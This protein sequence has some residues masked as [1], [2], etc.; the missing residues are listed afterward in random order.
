LSQI[1]IFPSHLTHL[2]NVIESPNVGHG[3]GHV[4]PMDGLIHAG[5]SNEFFCPIFQ[6]HKAKWL[7]P[8]AIIWLFFFFCK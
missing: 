5:T 3:T 2:A 6:F 4:Q 1:D 8:M 7:P